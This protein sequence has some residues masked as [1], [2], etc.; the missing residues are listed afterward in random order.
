MYCTKCGSKNEENAL[1]C[2]QCGE[3]LKTNNIEELTEQE[4]NRIINLEKSLK[5]ANLILSPI[6]FYIIGRIFFEYI[7]CSFLSMFAPYA[8]KDFLDE[9]PFNAYIIAA[10]ILS[11]IIRA[12]NYYIQNELAKYGAKY[13]KFGKHQI[14]KTT[15]IITSKMFSIFGAQYFLIK[16]N[17]KGILVNVL[18]ISAGLFIL[19]ALHF[20]ITGKIFLLSIRTFYIIVG[21]IAGMNLSDTTIVKAKIPDKEGKIMIN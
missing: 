21:I 11:I 19:I 17:T 18:W 20:N 9:F 15:Y 10:C 6:I 8:F 14:N 4:K 5:I 12:I 16:E 13:S 7:F 1:K 2:S 3:I